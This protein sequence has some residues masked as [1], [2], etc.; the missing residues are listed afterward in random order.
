MDS[1][2]F[3]GDFANAADQYTFDSISGASSALQQHWST[4]Y[5]ESDIQALAATGLNALRIPIGY[6]A[7]NN[8]GTPYL[9]GAD[10]YLDQA[11]TWARAA[12][13]YVWVDCHGS[14]GSQNGFDNSG[15]AGSVDWQT[16]ANLAAS[17]AVLETMAKKYGAMEYADVVVGLE[18]TNEPISYGNNQFSVTQSWAQKAYSSVKA[19]IENPSLVVVMH[20]AFQGATAWT[21]VASTLI[22]DGKKTFGI[23]T[24]L[25][26]LYTD[27]D[28]ALTQ[29]EHIT[30]ACNWATDL[31]LANAVMPTYVGEFSAATNVC[32]NPDGTTT[33]GTTCAV[34]GC[35]C[36]SADFDD[37]NAAM[38]KQ[39]RMFVEAQLD[40]FEGSARKF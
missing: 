6:W 9:T 4:Y 21:N 30:E 20:D 19:V 7:Y 35:Q 8:T 36:Q 14:P 1:D 31:A 22:G 12:G 38:V 15:H 37:L 28:N 10:A 11:I 16:D 40:V 18:M 23:D 5:T 39:M 25:Y 34:T 33:A 17:I 2:A 3:T 32:V 26:Q 27:A 29:A 13:M 24:H